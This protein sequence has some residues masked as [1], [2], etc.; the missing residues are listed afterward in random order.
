MEI[1]LKS[2]WPTIDRSWKSMRG[3]CDNPVCHNTHLMRTIPGGRTG[4]QSGDRWYCSVDCFATGSGPL[5][6]ELAQ[7][8]FAGNQR[9]PRMSLGLILVSKGLLST[10]QLRFAQSD[11]E[12]NNESLESTLLRHQLINER[13]LA[14]ARAAQ[15]GYPL[16]HKDRLGSSVEL[17]IPIILLRE[18]SA[19]PFEVSTKARR[20]LIGFVF[21]VEHSLLESIE[22]ITGFQVVPCFTTDTQY[23]QQSGCLTTGRNYDAV[24]IPEPGSV[25][26]MARTLGKFAL[27]VGAK[28]AIFSHCKNFVWSRMTG[29]KGV[30]D[31][32]F[33]FDDVTDPRTVLCA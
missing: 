7:S 14:A 10:D 20:I 19:V 15:W 27:E 11:A 28:E 17:D 24:L 32:V 13:Q 2:L 4:I 18:F 16:L 23:A 25:D 8:R 5:L 31:V 9:E 21:R 1:A 6:S 30:F 22:K 33:R 3:T 29:T 12:M 26:R